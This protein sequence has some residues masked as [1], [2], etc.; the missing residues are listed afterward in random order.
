MRWN[1]VT[2]RRNEVVIKEILDKISSL[3]SREERQ[4]I[5]RADKI[6]RCLLKCDLDKLWKREEI[7][8]RQKAR[9]K[10]TKDGDRNTKYFHKIANQ[11]R[12]R[13][14]ISALRVSEVVYE[15]GVGLA[16][17]VVG[18]YRELYLD[19]GGSRPFP[20]HANFSRLD[21]GYNHA[22]TN[23]FSEKEVWEVRGRL[24]S[25]KAKFLSF[26]G[27]LTLLKSVLSQLLIYY[28]SL[29]QAPVEVLKELERI[30][31]NF[32]WEGAGGDKRP[33]LVV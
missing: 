26:G 33:H 14:F 17:A 12:R 25:W 3:D 4:V 23:P 30:Q 9:E 11:N 29:F 1:E 28:L 15:D 13:N 2:F 10:W 21:Q 6:E 32:L 22:L 24:D 8:W 20:L 16:G 27:R 7:S 5:S 31:N 19:R 18:F